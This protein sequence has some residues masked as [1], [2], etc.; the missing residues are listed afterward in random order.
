MPEL[1]INRK[2]NPNN[3]MAIIVKDEKKSNIWK[4]V[5]PGII[6]ALVGT[7]IYFTFFSEAPLIANISTPE[8]YDELERISKL[9]IDVNGIVESPVWKSLKVRE[10]VV[11]IDTSLKEKRVSPMEPL[12]VKSQAPVPTKPATR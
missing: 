1:R 9:K 8:G 5:L 7:G 2:R 10:S 3:H 6:T 12:D 11:Q 4:F